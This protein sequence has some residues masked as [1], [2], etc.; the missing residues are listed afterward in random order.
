[1]VGVMMQPAGP[2]E[3]VQHPAGEPADDLG[4]VRIG[5]EQDELVDREAVAADGDAL[6]QLRR[7]GAA[8][9]DDRDLDAHAASVLP[10]R[11]LRARRR[12]PS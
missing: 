7:V 2:S 11:V 9:A 8:A 1:M 6:D 3:P 12:L 5:V 10:V 4:A